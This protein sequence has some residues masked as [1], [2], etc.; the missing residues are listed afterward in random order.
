MLSNL[1]GAEI[2][3]FGVIQKII[4]LLVIL[5]IIEFMERVETT[6]Y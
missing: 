2:L 1:V 3:I 5:V 4:I 6:L